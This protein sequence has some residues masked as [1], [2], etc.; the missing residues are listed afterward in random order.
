MVNLT[1]INF[2]SKVQFD[3]LA[4]TNPEELYAVRQSVVKEPNYSA[5]VALNANQ[6]YV[7]RYDCWVLWAANNTQNGV[8]YVNE[9]EFARALGRANDW[10]DCNS[11]VVYIPTGVSYRCTGATLF[12][13]F[14]CKE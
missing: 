11:L 4:E 9:I 12:R 5:P 3:T 10:A 6:T 14:P 13:L 1:N 2:M 7:A 8:F